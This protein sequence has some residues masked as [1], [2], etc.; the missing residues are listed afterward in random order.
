MNLMH[1]KSN[2][3][4]LLRQYQSNSYCI[5]SK[6]A[7]IFDSYLLYFIEGMYRMLFYSTEK[8]DRAYH[9]DKSSFPHLKYV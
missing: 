4:E 9:R 1:Q 7:L 3:F 8:S 6:I 5:N 2:H